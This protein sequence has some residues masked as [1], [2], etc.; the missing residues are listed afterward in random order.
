MWHAW[1]GSSV[2]CIQATMRVSIAYAHSLISCLIFG[3]TTRLFAL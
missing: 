2:M 1:V 3:V